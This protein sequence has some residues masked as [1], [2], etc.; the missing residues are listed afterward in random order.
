VSTLA[1]QLANG[2]HRL[3]QTGLI[4]GENGME[5]DGNNLY[6][7]RFHIFFGIGIEIGNPGNKNGK[8]YYR[9]QKRSE[10]E[11]AWIQ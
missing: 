11:P 10:N 5:T 4:R 2:P 9:N 6:C 7:F 8:E 3:K 1:N